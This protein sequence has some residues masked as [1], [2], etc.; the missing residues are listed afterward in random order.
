MIVA[1]EGLDN[2]GKTTITNLLNEYYKG[3]SIKIEI[4]K[5][6]LTPIGK[7]L[8]EMVVNDDIDP[9]LKAYL[10]AA[11][12][13]YRMKEIDYTEKKIYIFDR[14]VPSAM[15][16]REAEGINL[17][18][19]RS[20]NEI[21]PTPDLCFFIDITAKE[22]IKRNTDTKFNIRYSEEYLNKV[23]ECYL[24]Y[25]EEY[26]MIYLDGNNKLEETM[27]EIVF[28]IDREIEKNDNKSKAVKVKGKVNGI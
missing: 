26:D 16:Y 8:K 20:I 21:F 27:M 15:A 18:W 7:I 5:E 4:S 9:T 3:K 14:Y 22:S 23:R 11:D 24:S 19:I 6:F 10:F 17:N 12:R 28:Y 1:L 13:Y 25:L 2:C